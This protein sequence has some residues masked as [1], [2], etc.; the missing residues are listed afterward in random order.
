MPR[1]LGKKEL[2]IIGHLLC[3]GVDWDKEGVD[4]KETPCAEGGSGGLIP[5]ALFPLGSSTSHVCSMSGHH[6]RRWVTFGEAMGSGG[7]HSKKNELSRE[8]VTCGLAGDR[9]QGHETTNRCLGIWVGE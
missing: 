5:H 3:V 1:E 9:V 8:V 6:L 7:H 4:G 2:A